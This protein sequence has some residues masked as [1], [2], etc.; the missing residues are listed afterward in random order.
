MNYK[1][2]I[3]LV[4][5]DIFRRGAAFLLDCLLILMFAVFVLLLSLG[6]DYLIPFHEKMG[7][8]YLFR[9]GISLVTLTL[10][11]ILFFTASEKGK[12]RATPGKRWMNIKVVETDTGSF[13]FLMRNILKFLP[14]EVAHTT[15]H[16]Y[17]DFFLTG[18]IT[19]NGEVFGMLLSYFLMLIYIATVLFRRDKKAPH[20]LISGTQVIKK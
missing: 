3:E 16:L 14:W 19:G 10:P 4:P 7:Q 17:P 6:I 13:G 5:A 11:V 15:Y 9:H 20:D 8:S 18:E 1:T 2:Q 12:H